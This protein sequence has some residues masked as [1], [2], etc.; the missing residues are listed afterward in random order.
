VHNS[1]AA[2]AATPANNITRIVGWKIDN[3]AWRFPSNKPEPSD[4]MQ[5]L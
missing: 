1:I 2:F 3:G 4:L 5:P